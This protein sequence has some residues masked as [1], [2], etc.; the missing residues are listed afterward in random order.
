MRREMLTRSELWVAIALAVFNALSAVAGGGGALLTGGFG[1][2]QSMLENS[3]FTSFVLP[4]LILLVVVGGTQATAAIQLIRRAPSSL[5]WNA[6]AGFGMIIWITT[7][8]MMIL[9]FSW[10]QVLYFATG[11]LQLA[12]TFG[13]LGIVPW[14]PRLSLGRTGFRR[15]RGPARGAAGHGVSG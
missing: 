15:R 11:V 12:L 14:A 10:L 9:G 3:P 4:A 2:P 6:V 1:A 8:V 7:E 5:L 13:L